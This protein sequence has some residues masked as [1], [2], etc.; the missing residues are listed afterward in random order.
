MTVGFVGLQLS[1]FANC[2]VLMDGRRRVP[3]RGP[4]CR[5]SALSR[6]TLT[7]MLTAAVEENKNRTILL[8]R[9][10]MTTRN[11]VVH[12]TFFYVAKKQHVIMCLTI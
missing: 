8:K 9:G 4:P 11:H 5:A 1:V 10:R 6:V 2:I 12:D 3:G 7:L